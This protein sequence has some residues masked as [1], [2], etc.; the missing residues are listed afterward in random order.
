MSWLGSGVFSHCPNSNQSRKTVVSHLSLMGPIQWACPQATRSFVQGC[1]RAMTPHPVGRDAQVSDPSMHAAETSMACGQRR[2]VGRNS[3]IIDRFWSVRQTEQTIRVNGRSVGR[4]E[5]IN[6][7]RPGRP[8]RGQSQ[9]V[10]FSN[11]SVL[12]AGISSRTRCFSGRQS[13]R[14]KAITPFRGRS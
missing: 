7:P 2:M 4:R 1:S 13:V 11:P 9:V 8:R 14:C 10:S 3:S 6:V 5:E 12:L